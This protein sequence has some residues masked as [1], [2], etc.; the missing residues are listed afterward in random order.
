[1]YAKIPR[2]SLKSGKVH[3]VHVNEDSF[4]RLVTLYHVGKCSECVSVY[5]VTQFPHLEA[6]Y[7]FIHLNLMGISISF[8]GEEEKGKTGNEKEKSLS[9]PEEESCTYTTHTHTP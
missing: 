1:M 2:E 8:M 9:S 4:A 5:G 6:F 7:P 3:K